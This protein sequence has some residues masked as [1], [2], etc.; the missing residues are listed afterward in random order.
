MVAGS[1][2]IPRSQRAILDPTGACVLLIV[3]AQMLPRHALQLSFDA[4]PGRTYVLDIVPG[5]PWLPHTVSVRI[6]DKEE[7]DAQTRFSTWGP[8]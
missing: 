8:S 4:R 1:D 7:Y 2:S 5:W 3:G 6:V